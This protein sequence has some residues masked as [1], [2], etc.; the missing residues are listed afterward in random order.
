MTILCVF[1]RYFSRNPLFGLGDCAIDLMFLCTDR[2]KSI[3][4]V[5]ESVWV[6]LPPSQ[7]KRLVI[8]HPGNSNGQTRIRLHL[9]GKASDGAPDCW[10]VLWGSNYASGFW[11]VLMLKRN[12]YTHTDTYTYYMNLHIKC[13][14]TSVKDEPMCDDQHHRIGC[15]SLFLK[16]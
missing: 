2:F 16:S 9:T 5:I 11:V 15:K 6:P 7:V 8:L 3:R 10:V 14:G 13:P 1:F 4:G 12:T